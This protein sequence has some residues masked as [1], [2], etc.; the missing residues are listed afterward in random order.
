MHWLFPL[1]HVKAKFGSIEKGYKRLTSIEIKFFRTAGYTLLD[2][3][4]NEEI[5]EKLKEVPVYEK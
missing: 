5:L 4:R 3:K 2:H 1:L